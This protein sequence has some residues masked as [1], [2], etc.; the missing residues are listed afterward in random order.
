MRWRGA[1]GSLC[2]FT[3]SVGHRLV[4]SALLACVFGPQQQAQQKLQCRCAWKRP[5]LSL[6]ARHGRAWR[7][8]AEMSRRMGLRQEGRLGERRR[9]VKRCQ[10]V[11]GGEVRN[12]NK[13]V[14][15][16]CGSQRWLADQQHHVGTRPKG[17][18]LGSPQTC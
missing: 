18:F 2:H 3:G 8:R 17:E 7:M 4:T 15:Q 11:F 5:L 13:H 9:K 14:Y 10:T 16:K 12:R 1:A 6:G